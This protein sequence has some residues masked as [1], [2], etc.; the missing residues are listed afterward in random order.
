[1]DKKTGHLVRQAKDQGFQVERNK[2]N[3]Y[4]IRTGAG[5]F[6]TVLASTPSDC[7]SWKNGVAAL[8][9]HGFADPDRKFR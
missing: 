6:V 9:R 5:D 2:K 4:V 7:R 8:R 1:M 3:H